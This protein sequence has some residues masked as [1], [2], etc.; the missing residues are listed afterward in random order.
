[1]PPLRRTQPSMDDQVT[2]NRRIEEQMLETLRIMREEQEPL[3]SSEVLGRSST[4][5]TSTNDAPFFDV[6]HPGGGGGVGGVA[7][8]GGAGGTWILED[9]IVAWD[10]ALSTP[11][12][13]PHSTGAFSFT[14]AREVLQRTRR[15]S[16]S[17]GFQTD[18]ERRATHKP[19][20]DKKKMSG[21]CLSDIEIE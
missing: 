8:T 7:H 18:E 4:T 16:A 19:A 17:R 11:R 3:L 12:T 6:T 1:M 2:A 9:N 13:I 10:D 15:P 20:K 21:V 14:R 5:T